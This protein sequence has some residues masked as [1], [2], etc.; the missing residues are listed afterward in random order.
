MNPSVTQAIPSYPARPLWDN[1]DAAHALWRDVIDPRGIGLQ[2]ALAED[3]AS[4]S[5]ESTADVL[6]KMERGKEDL[7]QL[8][9][10]SRIDVGD[11]GQV[12]AFYREQF[13]EAY[14]LAYWHSGLLNGHPPLNYPFAALLARQ[15]GLR[16]ALDFGSGIGTGSLCLASVGCEVHSADI[17][18]ELLRL[19]SHRLVRH[20]FTTHPLDLSSGDRPRHGYY[21]L[22]TCFDVLEHIPNQLAKLRE[23]TTYLRPGGYLLV[24]LMQDSSHPDRPMHISSAGN[25]LALVRKTALRPDWSYFAGDYQVLRRA[26]GARV[27]NTAASLVDWCQGQGALQRPGCAT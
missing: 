16:K 15:L 12:E 11:A 18:R 2:R 23:L 21:D 25:W 1:R 10:Q 5:G 17:A 6:R 7:K 3:L 19:A 4:F 22:I 14:E 24:N 13:V 9:E 8:W 26:P 20:G 27:W